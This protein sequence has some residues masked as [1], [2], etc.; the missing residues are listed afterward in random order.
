MKV[1]V[2]TVTAALMA[3]GLFA[4]SSAAMATNGY[5]THGVGTESKA[6]GGS[7]VGSSENPDALLY[8]L[9]WSGRS[10]RHFFA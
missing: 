3:T 10:A 1:K 4:F 6:M 9:G 7:G 8:N 2:R 5:F